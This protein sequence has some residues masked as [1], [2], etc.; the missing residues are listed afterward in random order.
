ML[1][2][3]DPRGHDQFLGALVRCGLRPVRASTVAQARELLLRDKFSVILCE[4]TIAGESYRA[5]LQQVGGFAARIPVVVFSRT[6][7]WDRYLVAM[8]AGAFDYIPDP[9]PAA[10]IESV[11]SRAL[12]EIPL[13]PSSRAGD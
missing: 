1:A 2:A 5:V 4:E 3:S 13:F 8:G 6:A 7:D 10:E 11:V 9:C 12:R